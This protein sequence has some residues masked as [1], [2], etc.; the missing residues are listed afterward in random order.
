MFKA[1]I[2]LEHAEIMR[3]VYNKFVKINHVLNN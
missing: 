1:Q 3:L 2:K